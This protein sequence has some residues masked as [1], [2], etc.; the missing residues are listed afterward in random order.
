[1]R[2]CNCKQ[3]AISNYHLYYLSVGVNTVLTELIQG[4]WGTGGKSVVYLCYQGMREI[5]THNTLQLQ[6]QAEGP[7]YNAWMHFKKM[8][9]KSP[10]VQSELHILPRSNAFSMST[11]KNCISCVQI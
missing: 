8:L 9:L 5:V 3:N 10:F 7:E 4:E 6:L 2:F 1:M 11:E